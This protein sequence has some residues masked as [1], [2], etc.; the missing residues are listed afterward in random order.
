MRACA[1]CNLRAGF[2]FTLP[3]DLAI[4]SQDRESGGVQTVTI[5]GSVS[6]E[7]GLVWL[8]ARTANP[9][10]IPAVM[11]RRLDSK[12]AQRN[13]FEGTNS[14]DSERHTTIGGNRPS[15]QSPTM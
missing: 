15:V 4:V 3:P 7:I 12:V 1:G 8:K 6:N 14:A 13:N 5:R 2:E 10:D 9:S 11:N